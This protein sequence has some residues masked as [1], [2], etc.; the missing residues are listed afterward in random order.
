[1]QVYTNYLLLYRRTYTQTSVGDDD[2]R[3][4]KREWEV[5]LGN[6]K[7]QFSKCKDTLVM[8]P[9]ELAAIEYT[10]LSGS[11]VK[12]S[13]K[14][15][16]WE[17]AHLQEPRMAQGREDNDVVELRYNTARVGKRQSTRE[18]T[19]TF[20]VHFEDGRDATNFRYEL[21][22]RIKYLKRRA[23]S[24]LGLHAQTGQRNLVSQAAVV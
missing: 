3:V 1:M 20:N 9:F 22:R 14:R 15:K 17:Y 8:D 5:R 4:I 12:R 6:N 18:I 19:T 2:D 23:R 7:M 11:D 16:A 13:S 21:D 24:I 10:G